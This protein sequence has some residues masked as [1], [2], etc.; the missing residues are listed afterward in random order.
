MNYRLLTG[1]FAGSVVAEGQ[2]LDIDWDGLDEDMQSR[3]KG[4]AT[5]KN[6]KFDSG[7]DMKEAYENSWESVETDEDVDLKPLSEW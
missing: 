6:L 5:D 1:P 7:N 2:V 3:V 4:W